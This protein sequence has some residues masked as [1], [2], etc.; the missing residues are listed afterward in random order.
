MTLTQSQLVKIFMVRL[1]WQI[2][3]NNIKL[4]LPITNFKVN[5][6]W[7]LKIYEVRLGWPLKI[8]RLD[9]LENEDF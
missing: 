5:L 6:G 2:K 3:I 1:G 8:L 9:L 7:Q 4:A